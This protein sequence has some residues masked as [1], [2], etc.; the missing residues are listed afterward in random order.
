[1]QIMPFQIG[2]ILSFI[3]K[4]GKEKFIIALANNHILDNGFEAFYNLINR[5]EAAGIACFG[6]KEKPYIVLDNARVILN[7]VTAE[8]VATLSCRKFLNYLF[9]DKKNILSQIKELRDKQIPLVFYPHW[10]RDMDRETFNTYGFRGN[11]KDW[12]VFGH[13]PHLISG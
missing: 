5:L 11:L 9:Y 8:T 10:G 6:T 1:Y 7:F 2:V 3:K 13:H 12:L 4:F